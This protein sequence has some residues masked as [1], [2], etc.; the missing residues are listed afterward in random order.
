LNKEILERAIALNKEGKIDFS[1]FLSELNDAGVQSYRVDVPTK[2]L[3]Y[4]AGEGKENYEENGWKGE[5]ALDIAEN[6]NEEEVKIALK[7]AQT[8]QTDFPSFL[9]E[10]GQAG[11][12][13]YLVDVPSRT[14]RYVGNGGSYEST[15][16]VPSSRRI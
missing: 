3:I 12:M 15:V 1:E 2:T 5:E 10:V 16:P 9:K 6:Y 8:K 13:Y 7:R 11:I 14:I 4:S